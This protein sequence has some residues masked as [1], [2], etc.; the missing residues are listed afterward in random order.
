MDDNA[1]ALDSNVE[2]FNSYL[3]NKLNPGT[4]VDLRKALLNTEHK[5]GQQDLF[6]IQYP[7]I[8]SR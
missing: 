8:G 3:H 2:A 6:S 7:L 4:D 5:S 1:G